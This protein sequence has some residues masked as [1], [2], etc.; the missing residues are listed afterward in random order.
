MGP[1]GQSPSL[2]PNPLPAELRALVDQALAL[3]REGWFPMDLDDPAQPGVQWVQPH[4]RALIPLEGFKVPRS[5]RA[6]VR[7]GAFR[8]TTDQAFGAVIRACAG[9]R[10]YADGTWLH[11]DIIALFDLFHATGHAHSVEAWLDTPT[12]PTLVGGLYGLAIGRVFCGES[13][14]SRPDLGGTNASKVCLVHLVSHLRARGFAVL[15][16]QLPN[17]HTDQFGATLISTERYQRLLAEHA[18]AEH[19]R[20]WL[21]WAAPTG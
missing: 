3:Y 2:P 19:A 12:G 8:I 13:M 14:F 6:R 4:E 5:L 9:P 20:A 10:S 16:A 11:P 17:H 21:P 18:G 1:P 7:R 15:D